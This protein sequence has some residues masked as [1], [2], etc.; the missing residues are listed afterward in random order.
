MIALI[1]INNL[2]LM[3]KCKINL[4]KLIIDLINIMQLYS[5]HPKVSFLEE[6]MIEGLIILFKILDL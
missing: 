4:C 2:I 1:T 5:Q 6:K 3:M